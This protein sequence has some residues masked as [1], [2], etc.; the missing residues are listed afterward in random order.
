MWLLIDFM[1]L[2][3]FGCWFGGG[4]ARR[5]FVR[6]FGGVRFEVEVIE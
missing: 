6:R 4:D 5:G 1:V 3:V 2:S